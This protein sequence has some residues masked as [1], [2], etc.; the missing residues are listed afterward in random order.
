[1]SKQP[2][3]EFH[4]LMQQAAGFAQSKFRDDGNVQPMWIAETDMGEKFVIATPFGDEGQKAQVVTLL[5]QMF[6][7]R[8][9]VRYAFMTEAWS[10]AMSESEMKD[11]GTNRPPPSKHPR[12]REVLILLGED[13]DT[14]VAAFTQFFILRPEDGTPTLQEDP[15][16]AGLS[17]A[18]T[19]QKFGG[20][21][22]R[23][24]KDVKPP[25]KH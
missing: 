9:V 22:S 5:R 13:R 17:T 14:K 3:P 11:E 4:S 25:T 2:T 15:S 1:M 20:L 6:A 8:S 7:E 18:E 19:A 10:V 23:M 12:R 16:V 24:F 21:F